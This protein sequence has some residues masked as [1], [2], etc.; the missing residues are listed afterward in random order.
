MR[1]LVTCFIA[2]LILLISPLTSF[3]EAGEQAVAPCVACHGEKGN[4]QAP[5]FPKLAGQNKK[6]LSKQLFDYQL[7]NRK[8]P[9]MQ[10]MAAS[11]SEKDIDD[12]AT[13]YAAQTIQQTAASVVDPDEEDEDDEE[14]S[15]ADD[16]INHE[17]L[18][19]IGELL[20]TSGNLETQVPACSACHAPDARGNALAGFPAL[21]SQ[22]ATYL[23]STLKQYREGERVND[24][25]GMMHK[26]A[27]RMSTQ[28]INAVAAYLADLK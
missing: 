7:N 14:E 20:Y 4:S 12:I 6:Y 23:A 16:Q 3:A 25:G 27:Q 5:I 8:N 22:H 10:G 15:E 17:E 26:T 24:T 21:R 1:K 28:E 9:T 11:L 13:Y 18:L 19:K 2:A